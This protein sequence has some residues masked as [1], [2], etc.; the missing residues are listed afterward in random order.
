MIETEKEPKYCFKVIHKESGHCFALI[1]EKEKLNDFV[2]YTNKNM[3]ESFKE[4]RYKES[5]FELHFTFID[6]NI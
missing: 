5:D 3:E 4:K 2:K 6:L 1:S